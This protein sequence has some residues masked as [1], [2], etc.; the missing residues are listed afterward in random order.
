MCTVFV[1]KFGS[2]SSCDRIKKR[3]NILRLIKLGW[4]SLARNGSWVL[5]AIKGSITP[6]SLPHSLALTRS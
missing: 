4:D 1:T 6:L 3:A 2:E 5:P